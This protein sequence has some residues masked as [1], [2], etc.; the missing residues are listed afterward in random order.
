MDDI[1]ILLKT[2][3]HKTKLMTQDGSEKTILVLL[4]HLYFCKNISKFAYVTWFGEEGEDYMMPITILGSSVLTLNLIS[5]YFV[6]RRREETVCRKWKLCRIFHFNYDVAIFIITILIYPLAAVYMTKMQYKNQ[7]G[8]DYSHDR[9]DSIGFGINEMND[10]SPDPQDENFNEQVETTTNI[11]ID[12]VLNI[13][14]GFISLMNMGKNSSE[15]VGTPQNEYNAVT[16]KPILQK[17][18][19]NYGLFIFLT[20]L[21][22]VSQLIV[23]LSLGWSEI[24]KYKIRTSPPPPIVMDE[25]NGNA[26][27]IQ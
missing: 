1:I 6:F 21:C 19:E 18:L 2:E 24:V 14:S 16:T 12:N 7:D 26:V 23:V 17:P 27:I 10:S 11:L 4:F 20:I 13:R 25:L 8:L 15:L 9:K 22:I 5:Y 3:E